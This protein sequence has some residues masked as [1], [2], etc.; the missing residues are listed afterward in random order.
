M[1][2]LG[3]AQLNKP[4]DNRIQ[5][6]VFHLRVQTKQ[7]EKKA[8]V[9]YE[10]RCWREDSLLEGLRREKR[11]RDTETSAAEKGSADQ[12][13]EAQTTTKE[14]NAEVVKTPQLMLKNNIW[15]KAEN[16]SRKGSRQIKEGKESFKQTNKEHGYEQPLYRTSGGC[17][18]ARKQKLSQ[19]RVI[20]QRAANS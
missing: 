10:A 18:E 9:T 14:R 1:T 19:R 5:A 6:K 4:R 2:V 16:C 3:E 7:K 12:K 15:E 17:G 11:E 8:N 13:S 20:F